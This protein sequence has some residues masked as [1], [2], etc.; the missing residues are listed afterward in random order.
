MNQPKTPFQRLYSMKTKSGI[1]KAQRIG[2]MNEAVFVLKHFVN[3]SARLLPFLEELTRKENPSDS[4]INDR[5]KIIAVYRNYSFDT[6][7]SKVLI[8]STILE[9][10][11]LAF[12]AII[13]PSDKDL[14][15]DLFLAD[16]LEEHERLRETWKRVDAN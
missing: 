11:Q 12:Y 13:Q 15:A 2:E 14:Q 4:D 3:L 1:M 7:A 5:N 9:K 6:K 16:F 8:N 10:I